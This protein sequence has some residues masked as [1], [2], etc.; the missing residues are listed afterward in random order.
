M[1][2]LSGIIC[3]MGDY[4]TIRLYCAK[5]VVYEE[6]WELLC[7]I[8]MLQGKITSTGLAI[9]GKRYLLFCTPLLPLGNSENFRE[10]PPLYYLQKL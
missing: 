1:V 10:V 8:A 4:R 3:L 6:L 7:D 9:I 5:M 2:R